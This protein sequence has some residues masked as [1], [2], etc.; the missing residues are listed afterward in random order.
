MGKYKILCFPSISLIGASISKVKQ[1]DASGVMINPLWNTQFWFPVMVSLIQDLPVIF[2]PNILALSVSQDQQ[3]SLYP[4]I[5]CWQFIYE[6][7]PSIS[8][9]SPEIIDV[10][11]E[12]GRPTTRSSY[13]SILIRWHSFP[14]SRNENLYSPNV[15]TVLEFLHG[16]YRNGYLYSGLCVARS[17]LSSSI[18]TKAYLKRSDHP[19]ISRYLKGIYYTHSTLPKYVD[20]WD[21]PVFTHDACV[22]TGFQHADFSISGDFFACADFSV[23]PHRNFYYNVEKIFVF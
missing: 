14:I 18:T 12:P 5:N 8:K 1:D 3:H 10:A 16:M 22:K 2:P 20:T 11:L 17:A 6:Q 9:H 7:I 21:K 13:E 4:K 15:T 19:L 23:S